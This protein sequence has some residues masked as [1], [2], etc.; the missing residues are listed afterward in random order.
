[1]LPRLKSAVSNLE[2]ILDCLANLYENC[3]DWIFYER[4]L[5]AKELQLKTVTLSV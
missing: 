2:E 5:F 4:S 3:Q 1:M